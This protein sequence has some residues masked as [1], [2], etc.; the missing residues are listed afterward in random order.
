M[1][2]SEETDTI[3]KSF[4]STLPPD[5]TSGLDKHTRYIYD[6]LSI[7]QQQSEHIIRE[8]VNVKNT[9]NSKSDEI[10]EL[11]KQLALTKERLEAYDRLYLA[12]TSK[13]SVFVGISTLLVVPIVVLVIADLV[14]KMFKHP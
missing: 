2:Y 10:S 14:I 7:I 12:F 6:A 9:L 8:Q 4:H 1:P 5:L 13:K 11:K 3:I